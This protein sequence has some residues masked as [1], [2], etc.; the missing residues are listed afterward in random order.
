[1]QNSIPVHIPLKT[2]DFNLPFLRYSDDVFLSL[3]ERKRRMKLEYTGD[4]HREVRSDFDGRKQYLPPDQSQKT[5]KDKKGSKKG[6]LLAEQDPLVDE[7]FEPTGTP[8]GQLAPL[9]DHG[10]NSRLGGTDFSDITLI[11]SPPVYSTPDP[12]RFYPH[13]TFL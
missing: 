10:F 9:Q 6:G 4:N 7:R 11:S 1:M 5:K 2:S 12:D 3:K 8:N 13:L